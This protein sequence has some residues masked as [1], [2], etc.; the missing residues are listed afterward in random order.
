MKTKLLLCVIFLCSFNVFAQTSADS[1]TITFRA[2]FPATPTMYLPGQFNGWTP[3]TAASQMTYNSSL[4]AWTKTYSFK[5]HDASDSRR[6]LGDSV[7]QYK[8][9]QGGNNWM[10]DPLNPEQNASD[11]NNSVLRMKKLF[12]FQFYQTVS[13]SNITRLTIGLVRANSDTITSVILHQGTTQDAVLTSMDITDCYNKSTRIIDTVLAT[14]FPKSNYIRLV[15]YNNHGDSVVYSKGGFVPTTLPVPIYAKKGVTLP[16]PA[17]NDSTSFWVEVP[18]SKDYV[19][20]KVVQSGQSIETATPLLMRRTPSP[21]G[22]WM[23]VKLDSGTY[24]YIY[25]IEPAQRIPDPYGRQVSNNGLTKFTVGPSGL[26]YDD[27]QWQDDGYNRPPLNKLIM[28]ELNVTEFAG[29][30]YNLSPGQVKWFRMRN[31]LSY[32]DSLGVNAIE[33]MPVMDYGNIGTSGFSWGYDLNSYFALEPSFGTPRDFKEFVD[34][35]HGRG[36]AVILDVVYNH[37]NETSALWQMNPNEASNPYFKLINDKRPNEDELQFFKDMDHWTQETQDLVYAAQKMWIDEYHIDGF[38]YD[39]TQGIGWSRFDTT[40]GILGWANKIAREYNNSIYQI[41]EH[42]PESPALIYYSGLNGGWH[43]SFRDEVFKHVVPNQQPSLST[44]E[45]LILG[46]G[47]YSSNDTPGSPTSYAD[48]TGPVNATSNHDEQSLFYEMVHY[49]HVDTATALQRDKL[50]A[51]FM[52]TSLGIP[53]LWEGI[54]FSAPRGWDGNKLDYRPVEWN[55]YRTARGKSHFQFYKTLIMQR[56]YNP[57]LY[58]GSLVKQYKYDSKKVLVWGFN[59]ADTGAAIEIIANLSNL[60]Q[61]VTNVPWLRTGTWY[62]VFDQSSFYSD[63]LTIESVTIPSYSVLIYT[64]RS[65]EELG[66]PLGVDDG[67]ME[68]PEQFSLAQ[69]YPNPFN[70]TTNF[71]FRISDFGLVTLKVFDILGREVA[72]IVNEELHPGVYDR[73]WNASNIPSGV[74]FYRLSTDAG[75]QVKKLVLM[76]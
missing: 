55:V 47:A 57:A 65:N 75:S 44:V 71:G 59:D 7:F 35:A 70:P 48:R 29:G 66:I 23:N 17:S 49:Q 58:Q 51:T 18:T 56:K 21:Y 67:M 37:L 1:V 8:L 53:M 43:D 52:F 13:G 14:P 72:M 19:L 4:S 32:L 40:K 42:L 39:Y 64:N 38:R 46:L 61:T 20:L 24:E 62:N 36:I 31:L 30:Y 5:I 60:P 50:Y 74:Y 16:S 76:R 9:N 68:L 10:P 2:H 54:E 41:A 11:N 6:T 33:L 27:Y 34:S 25:E 28:Y 73:K 22:W 45:N 26:T 3:N 63:S 69:N 15:A 12:W